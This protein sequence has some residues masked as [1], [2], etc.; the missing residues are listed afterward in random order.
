M[1][2]MQAENEEQCLRPLNCQL[3]VLSRSDG[4]A[5]FTQGSTIPQYDLNVTIKADSF[6]VDLIFASARVK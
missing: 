6:D 3:N 4:S 5:M 1:Y 2:K